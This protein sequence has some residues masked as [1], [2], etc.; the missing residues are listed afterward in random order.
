[1]PP[2][3]GESPP[4][5]PLKARIRLLCVRSGERFDCLVLG[6]MVGLRMHWLGNRST[7][8]MGSECQHCNRPATWKGY[9]PVLVAGHS[10]SGKEKGWHRWVLVISEE[11]GSDA[12]AW[13]AGQGVTVFRRGSKNNGP[14]GWQPLSIPQGHTCPPSFDVRPYVLR[15]CGLSNPTGSIA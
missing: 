1:M 15:A 10:P 2:V 9:A 5:R 11:V 12:L 13:T 8:C 3:W 7:P 4:E 14:M 6:P